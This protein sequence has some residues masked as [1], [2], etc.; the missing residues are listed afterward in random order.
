MIEFLVAEKETVMNIHKHLCDVYGSL[1][2]TRSTVSHW[3]QRTK[4]SGRGD[5]ELH[6]RARCGH[7]ATVINSEIVKCAEDIILNDRRLLKN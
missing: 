1:A 5:M 3:V 4:E 2:D 6:D 7:P